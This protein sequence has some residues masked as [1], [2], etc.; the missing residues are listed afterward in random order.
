MDNSIKFSKISLSVKNS[1][2]TKSYIS[3]RI[4]YLSD[5]EQ[6][7]EI[8]MDLI[9]QFLYRNP[10][11]SSIGDET[12][13]ENTED[14]KNS[15]FHS[16]NRMSKIDILVNLLDQISK[17]QEIKKSLI[18]EKRRLNDQVLIE[19][20]IRLDLIRRSEENMSAY[21]DHAN[22]LVTELERKQNSIHNI[23]KK[24]KEVEI[25]ANREFKPF[26]KEEKIC[27]FSTKPFFNSHINYKLFIKENLEALGFY[28]GELSNS[29][30]ENNWLKYRKHPNRIFTEIERRQTF[31]LLL[32]EFMNL[33][34]IKLRKRFY[35]L[36]CLY[37]SFM[38]KERKAL[39]K[40]KMEVKLGR[41]NNEIN[42]VMT[43]QNGIKD[44]NINSLSIISYM[45]F[46][47]RDENIRENLLSYINQ[48]DAEKSMRSLSSVIW[49]DN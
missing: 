26:I 17:R 19:S 24:F 22:S 5:L 12:T 20:Q 23:C 43:T 16:F 35:R 3:H 37:N 6:T 44:L 7:W 27:F 4:P 48:V 14:I 29:K 30:K 11:A 36:T 31:S 18:E 49:N 21:E 10:N 40:E 28:K 15:G 45:K 25:F 47:E 38:D 1:K 41:S 33:K 8:N 9:R 42:A 39:R 13:S 2:T 34:L 32:L 46:S